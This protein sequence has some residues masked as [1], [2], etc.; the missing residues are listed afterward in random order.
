MDK[1]DLLIAFIALYCPLYFILYKVGNLD[2]R[3]LVAYKWFGIHYLANCILKT[4]GSIISLYQT[5]TCKN[6]IIQWIY[7]LFF[8]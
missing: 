2:T 4:I 5:G 8:A 7:N 3:H 6:T 1:M